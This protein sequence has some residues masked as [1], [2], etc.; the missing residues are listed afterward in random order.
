MNEAQISKQHPIPQNFM[1]VEF[2]I[3]GDF[4]VRQ[5]TYLVAAGLPMYAIYQSPIQ[6]FIKTVLLFVLGLLGF[7]LV[8]VPIDDRGMDVWIVN[9][10][11]AVYANNRRV[12]RKTTF[13]PKTLSMETIKL[14][15]GEMIT[16]APTSSRRKLEEYL[17]GIEKEESDEYD[18]N[19]K[20]FQYSYLEE[21]PAI[22]TTI[23]PIYEQPSF[24]PA[25]SIVETKTQAT[26]SVV[27]A[28]QQP[29]ISPEVV[30]EV[31]KPEESVIQN[32]VEE[33][34]L[35]IPQFK[36]VES[37]PITQAPSFQVPKKIIPEIKKVLPTKI[38]PKPQSTDY[39]H[40]E[41]GTSNAYIPGRKF[42]SFS[43][44]KEPELVL[45]VRGERIIN[46]FNQ[47]TPQ[48]TKDINSI[49]RELRTL[50][51]EIKTEVPTETLQP[52]ISQVETQ[53]L[54]NVINGIVFDSE[55]NSLANTT[56]VLL[57]DNNNEL[58]YSRTDNS[59]KFSFKGTPT[60]KLKIKVLNPEIFRLNFDIIN[61]NVERYPYSLIQI[62]GRK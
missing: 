7:L 44:K 46:I 14:V 16:L 58:K 42:V 5:F 24:S 41:L 51:R 61:I 1:D 10:F 36:P 22:E 48:P 3:V 62:L 54:N 43:Q 34:V 40:E 50:V 60:G 23:Q 2:K 8:F 21:A 32:K 26:P 29:L 49:T 39:I 33:I 38:T 17:K 11:K 37:K 25:T 55:N 28:V 12:W 45:P 27:E 30:S 15:Q 59:G 57:D 56:L 31:V 9:F 19:F 35:K 13:V 4:T 20:K 47:P 52:I 6:G 53:N 18:F